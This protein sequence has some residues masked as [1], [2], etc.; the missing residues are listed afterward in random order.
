MLQHHHD[1]GLRSLQVR[2]GVLEECVITFFYRRNSNK[3]W[4]PKKAGASQLQEV[5]LL[6][7]SGVEVIDFYPLC[8]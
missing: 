5:T 4:F 2:Q 6:I 7:I 1:I 8:A 3:P